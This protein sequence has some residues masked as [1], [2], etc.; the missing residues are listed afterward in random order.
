MAGFRFLVAGGLLLA[1]AFRR[2]DAEGDRLGWPQW[3]AAAIV[4]GLLLLGGNGGVVWAEQRVSSGV[5]AL[6][7]ATVPIWMA[8]FAARRDARAHPAPRGI[9]LV[10]GFAGTVLLARTSGE[11][12]GAVDLAGAARA[13]VRLDLV[14]VRLRARARSWPPEAADGDHGHG[15]DRRRG[16][17]RARRGR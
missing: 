14:G 9:G 5:A 10:L 8:L 15:D 3:R 1:F 16:P 11:G 13:R 17:A 7:V 4:G 6:I 12:G 2:G